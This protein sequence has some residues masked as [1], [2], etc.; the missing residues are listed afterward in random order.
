MQQ[1]AAR[2]LALLIGFALLGLV[3]LALRLVGLGDPLERPD[4]FAGFSNVQPAFREALGADGRRYWVATRDRSRSRSFRAEKPE[5]GFRA[6]VFGGSSEAGTPYGYEYSFAAFLREQL[7]SALPDREIEVVN[8]AVDGYGSRR[9]LTVAEEVARHEPDLFVISVGHN[10]VIEQRHYQ[11]LIDYPTWLFDLR[12]ALRRLHLAVLVEDAV[13]QARQARRP[14]IELTE[15]FPVIGSQSEDYWGSDPE[16]QVRQRHYALALLRNNV[17]RMIHLAR[18]AGARVVLMSQSKNY[19]DWPVTRSGEPEGL[20]AAELARWQRASEAARAAR[21]AGQTEAAVEALRRALALAPDHAASHEMLADALRARGDLAA[22]ARHYRRAHDAMI[23]FGTVPE[24]NA[25]LRELAREHGTLW[26]DME[27]IFEAESPGGLVGFDWFVDFL[28]PN[29]AGHQRMAR[30]VLETLRRA[31][32]PRPAGDWRPVAELASPEV[33]LSAQ[34]RLRVQELRMQ[35][36][37]ELASRRPE[38]AAR[39]LRELR[40]LAPGD[41]QL[42]TLEAWVAGEL[43]FAP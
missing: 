12:Q 35:V 1:V 5:P 20:G 38:A 8:C 18:G 25:L 9:L 27:A 33:L 34:P 43:P 40:R 13:G 4:P 21:E 26:I 16:L 7:A 36:V 41:P 2:V 6:F 42:E 31:G 15:A 29:L 30:A 14:E 28:H 37:A 23:Q 24:R 3:E 32:V 39:A 22:A 19:A 11:H 17:E 10:E